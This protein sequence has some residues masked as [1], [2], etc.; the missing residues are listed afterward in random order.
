MDIMKKRGFCVFIHPVVEVQINS[1]LSVNARMQYII[2][3]SADK[4]IVEDWEVMDIESINYM[5]TVLDSIDQVEQCTAYH[6]SI[7]VDLY[8]RI[9]E[10]AEKIR[11]QMT[12]EDFIEMYTPL[13]VKPVISRYRQKW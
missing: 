10:T 2:S 3:K 1:E 4:F 12:L 13:Q 5:D 8:A 11:S 6:K 7:G 9:S